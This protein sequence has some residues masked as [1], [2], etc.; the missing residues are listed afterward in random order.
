MLYVQYGRIMKILNLFAGIGGN[1]TLWGDYHEITAV[2]F[3]LD[4]AKIYQER[5]PKDL[6]IITDALGFVEKFMDEYD[7]IW[8][9]PVCKTHSRLNTTCQNMRI[10]DITSL[11]GLIIF[12]D[13]F[14]KGKYCVENVN[15]YYKPLVAPTMFLGRHCF[16]SNFL[17]PEKKFPQPAGTL[18]DLPIKDLQNWHQITE[19]KNRQYLRNCV[20]YRIGKYILDC[21]T[22]RKQ[23]TLFT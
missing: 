14:H 12:L 1:R 15:P 3:D 19:T 13:R 6:V 22:K 11:Y 17:I 20:D 8:A 18:K 7:F 16:W 9:S 21:A 5:F 10:P 2:E 23:R 4:I